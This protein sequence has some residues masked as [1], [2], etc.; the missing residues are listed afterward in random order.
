MTDGVSDGT[1][2][3]TAGRS[4][5]ESALTA[6]LK[7][8]SA[9]A[10]V[11]AGTDADPAVTYCRAIADAGAAVRTGSGH[12]IAAIAY[13]GDEWLGRS[14][15]S[16]ADSASH[17]AA[18]LATALSD[19]GCDGTVLA[20]P[21][22][23]HDAALYLEN[24]GFDLASTDVVARARAAK[25]GRE[26]D[27]IANAQT[28]ASA[29]LRRAA[30]LLADATVRDEDDRLVT[31]DESG[32]VT[33]DRLR[34]AIDEAI[35]SAGAFPAGNTAINPD[36][37]VDVLRSGEPIVVAVAPRGP[38]G[39]H[40]GLVRT[41]VVD[42]DGGRERRTHVA[43]TQAFRSSRAMLSADTASV[44]AVEADLEAE[45]RAFGEQGGIETR[46]TGVGLESRERPMAGS[47]EIGPG[48]VVRL[49]A[50]VRVADE[51]ATQ[52]LRLADLFVK[53][54]DGIERF[55]AP[56]RSLQPTA[57]LE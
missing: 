25:T 53:T 3:G 42:S 19:R 48:S 45:I 51:P 26:R 22:I 50:G 52:W 24:A 32:P 39:Y 6:V 31:G 27:R 30:A 9:A 2:D 36:S 28:A 12:D 4:D 5:L 15:A 10:F 56:S 20:P 44:T 23:P 18:E 43:V 34:T 8:R 17:P 1:P 41:L 49:D 57:L 38:A 13:D 16:V 21:R 29:G 33:T 7:S 14:A 47:E 55:D 54:T 46:V 37:G 40:G 35:V 11:H